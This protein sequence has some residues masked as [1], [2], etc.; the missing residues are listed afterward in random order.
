VTARKTVTPTDDPRWEEPS[1]ARPHKYKQLRV[2]LRQSPGRW[3]VVNDFQYPPAGQVG[4]W[5]RQGFE[6][7]TRRQPDGSYRLYARW[8]KN[9]DK[10]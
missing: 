3:A 4:Y 8:P 5:K 9:G 10:P 6:L 2:A 7:Q 1:V